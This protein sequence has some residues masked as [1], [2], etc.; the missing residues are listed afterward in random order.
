MSANISEVFS[1]FSRKLKRFN[2]SPDSKI[3]KTPTENSFLQEKIKEKSERLRK[4]V[5]AT[6]KIYKSPFEILGADSSRASLIDADEQALLK[7]YNLYKSVMDLNLENQDEIG[8]THIK[9]VEIFS[10]LTQKSV[11]VSGGQFVYLRA[12]LV[13]EKNCVQYVPFFENLNGDVRLR[14]EKSG[15]IK[16]DRHEEEI[17]RIIKDEFYD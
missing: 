16:I 5:C 15:N 3:V 6:Y 11:Y 1:R 17:L 8:S 4:N 2:D 13:F 12:W 14:F 10:P 9:N 7:A